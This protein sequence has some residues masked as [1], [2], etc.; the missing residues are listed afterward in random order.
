MPLENFF[1]RN[2]QLDVNFLKQRANE[3]WKRK[4][5]EKLGSTRFIGA[6]SQNSY[7]LTDKQ[8]AFINEGQEFFKRVYVDIYKGYTE[9]SG[10]HLFE[11]F[12]RVMDSYLKNNKYDKMLG[13][14]SSAEAGGFFRGLVAFHIYRNDQDSKE[15]SEAEA[16]FLKEMEPM[17]TFFGDYK[18]ARIIFVE[19][20]LHLTIRFQNAIE[21]LDRNEEGLENLVHFVVTFFLLYTKK[22]QHSQNGSLDG[23]VIFLINSLLESPEALDETIKEWKQPHLKTVGSEEKTWTID[24]LL[25]KSPIETPKGLYLYSGKDKTK[26]SFCYPAQVV[27]DAEDCKLM[28]YTATI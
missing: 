26:D 18:G 21:L 1:N 15:K 9:K 14:P 16:K 6:A 24:W 2:G 10:I 22:Y 4:G 20:L 28:L 19:F 17:V 5:G 3:L 8:I 12:Q 27:P 11:T 7:A 25:H 23:K 13:T